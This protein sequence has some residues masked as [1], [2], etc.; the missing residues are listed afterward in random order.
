[1]K[2]ETLF[3]LSGRVALVTGASSGLG[4]RFTRVLANNGATVIAAAR[5]LDR[6]EALAETIAK[7]GGTAHPV[8][9]DV[10]DPASVAAALEYCEA[11]AGTPTIVANNAGVADQGWAMEMSDDAWRRVI[12]IN[13][14]S[15]F[16]VARDVAGRMRDAGLAG[17]IVNTASIL[18]L[19][20]SKGL[21]AYAVSK[22]AV[23]QL[24]AALA[25]EWGRFGIRVNALAPGYFESE[26]T[27]AHLASSAGQAMTNAIPMGR[28]GREGELDGA[29]LL[30]ASDAGSYINGS[31]LPVDGGHSLEIMS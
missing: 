16:R 15:V 4:H 6:L 3:D 18:G 1:M 9:M 27:R 25:A 12:D 2:A 7:D 22:A 24:T 13:L 5:R 28:H 11:V 21:A 17:S 30:L 10:G 23:V 8:A 19:R 26:M 14:D 31:T 29:L 20:V